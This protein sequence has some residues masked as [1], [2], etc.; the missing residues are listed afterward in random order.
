MAAQDTDLV[1]EPNAWTQITAGDTTAIRVQNIGGNDVRLRAAVGEVAPSAEAGG[2]VLHP[3]EAI[4][5]DL[6]LAQ[7]HPSVVG[8]NRVY[9]YCAGKCKL[10]VSHG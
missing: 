10:S 5:A 4:S 2:I 7:W 1:I 9:A 3:G 6:T 8:G